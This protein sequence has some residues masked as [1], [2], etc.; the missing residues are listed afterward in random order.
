M[1]RGGRR[2]FPVVSVPPPTVWT[3]SLLMPAVPDLVA[4]STD[5]SVS[6][7]LRG[8]FFTPS[9]LCDHIVGWG[10][11]AAGDRVLEP[12]CGEAAFLLS[13]GRRL[14]DMGSDR[15]ALRGIE[16]HPESA[17]AA[18]TRLGEAGLSA[19]IDVADFFAVPAERTVD[20]VLGNPP[21][22][23]FHDFAGI[24]A[25]RARDVAARSGVHL[26][27]L[28]SSW[29]AFT[30]HAASFLRPGGR[31]GLVVPAELLSVNYAGAVR[32]FLA[33]S[34]HSVRLV[35]FDTRTF[36]GVLQE[37]VLLLAD[38][39]HRGPVSR[40]ETVRVRAAEEL[41]AGVAPSTDW[42]PAGPGDRWSEVLLDAELRGVF[43]AAS[44][45]PGFG[46]LVD[47]GETSLGMVTGNNAWFVRSPAQADAL[48]LGDRE[49]LPVAP[50]GSGH[51]RGLEFS[52]SD[53][54]GMGAAGRATI[55]LRPDPD[56]SGAAGELVRDGVAAGVDRAYKCRVR[57]PWWR[58]PLVDPPDLF[59]T[60]MNADTPRLVANTAG[61]RHL[62][63][64]HGLYLRPGHRP[65]RR[66]LALA[67]LNSLTVLGAEVVGRSYGGGVLKLEPGEA[68]RLPVPGPELVAR[69]SGRLELLRPRVEA[70]LS[71]RR[72]F[73]A[74]DLVDE[75]V[76]R[77][78][79]GL[80]ADDITALATGHRQLRARRVGRRGHRP[81]EAG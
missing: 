65:H 68:D 69:L 34:F 2:R 23:R 43:H 7:K 20:V 61:V 57:R 26:S 32:R 31:L 74:V 36:P 21:F 44:R 63:S 58:V 40:W 75:V 42:R 79:L 71:D 70:L 50:A 52:R 27:R 28:A 33:E 53:W 81:R 39:F 47:W 56:V 73:D 62:N 60:A 11:R 25:A 4:G 45:R 6:R 29:A 35:L 24:P 37:V 59:V 8:A 76:L 41:V 55:L 13:A 54:S 64:V 5:T 15:P 77:S 72:V 14:R 12:S 46:R 16:I 22:V 30:V 17:A 18:R 9:L 48:G 78:G 10:V 19:R 80:A 49:R 1:I 51:L 38:G 3:V 67:A 66:A